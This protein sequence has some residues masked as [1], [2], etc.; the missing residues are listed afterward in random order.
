MSDCP[1]IFFCFKQKELHNFDRDQSPMSSFDQQSNI[2]K[3]HMGPLEQ[4]GGGSNNNYNEQDESSQQ[5]LLD[6]K[7]INEMIINNP[8]LLVRLLSKIEKEQSG[9]R[10]DNDEDDGDKSN[11][12]EDLFQQ[13]PQ[14]GKRR[15][16]VFNNIYHQCRIQ[17]RKEKNLCLY[18]ANLYQNLK[19]FHGL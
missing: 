14:R 16:S 13:L 9:E 5:E 15:V 8:Y 12:V 1:L 11:D 18:L 19:G 17:K 7:I 6:E 4:S 2:N 3:Y 10:L